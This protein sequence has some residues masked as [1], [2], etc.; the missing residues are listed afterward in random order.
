MHWEGPETLGGTREGTRKGWW[1]T[2]VYWEELGTL[3]EAH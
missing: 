1:R 3:W 2:E